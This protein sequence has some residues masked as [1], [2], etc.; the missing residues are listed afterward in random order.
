MARRGAIAGLVVGLL[1]IAVAYL[2]AA[3]CLPYRITS[4]A[5]P[6]PWVCADPEY[7]WFGDMAF[8]VNL[9]TNDLGRAVLLSPLALAFYATLGML[10]GLGLGRWRPPSPD[11][12]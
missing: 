7:A 9:L 10:V 6:W 5:P 12:S 11:R 8:P 3:R 1:A 4:P 2:V